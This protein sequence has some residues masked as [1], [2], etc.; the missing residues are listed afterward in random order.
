MKQRDP[1]SILPDGRN[2]EFWETDPVW[3]KELFVNGSDL[4]SSDD[5][6]GSEGAPFRTIGRA[7][8]L[9]TP[10]TRV[11]IHAGTYRESVSPARG[12]TDP[13][14]MISYEAF[15]DGEVILSAAEIVTEFR[16]SEGWAVNRSWGAPQPEGIRIWEYDLDPDVFRG[17]NPFCAVNILHD[18][19]FIEYDKTDMT[20]YLNRR[21]CVFCDGEPLKQVP[22]YNGMGQEENTYWVEA[23]GM[24]V[25]FRLRG[26][27]DPKDHTIEVTVREQCFAPE[28]EF[29]NYIRV[30]GLICEKAATGAPVPQRG[31]ISAH[32]GHHWII[33]DC[34]VNWSNGVAIDVGH[35]CWHHTHSEDEIIGWSVIRRC[36]IRDAGVCGIA[37]MFAERLLIE[38][39]VIEG[40]GW[41]K[42]ELSWEAGAIKL[43]NSV[44]GL[45]RRN[46]FRNTI[47][48]DHVWLDC[49]N[50]NNRITGNLF[51]DGIEQREAIFIE[52]TRDGINLI[53]N[54]IIWNVPGRFDPAKIPQEPGSSG[55]YK[56][57]ELDVV[58]GY[59]VYG[60]GTD[61]LHIAHNLIGNCRHS[62]YYMKPVGFRMHGMDRGG[63]GRDAK[64]INNIFYACGEAAI[65]FPTRDNTAEGNLYVRM[66]GGYLRVMYPEPEV[67]LNLPAWKEFCGFDREGQNAWFDIGV[68]GETG[69]ITMRKAEDGPVGLPAQLRR[70]NMILDPDEVR[71]VRPDEAV[72]GGDGTEVLPGPMIEFYQE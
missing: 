71:K 72:P 19:L 14:H 61:R 48:A 68:D 55:W 11:R 38:D 9:A 47:R 28:K 10:G 23:N 58:N 20:T 26:D 44:N 18:R 69:K 29:L 25:H 41:Q 4:A 15:G 43:H 24:K 5:N 22:L 8:Q 49:G 17:Y 40:T 45:I 56:L 39:N 57:R 30:K 36:R 70:L 66:N 59:G 42:M 12:G 64:I 6:D 7:A 34:E 31:A 3:E 27:E 53:D 33:E 50:E 60:E 2:Y 65:D 16:A 1:S 67:C 51:L 63:T 21:G 35:E 37:G 13:D 62:G 32:R 52:C 54:N 46:I